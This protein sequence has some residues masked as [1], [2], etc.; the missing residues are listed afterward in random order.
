MVVPRLCIHAHHLKFGIL[1]FILE[2]VVTWNLKLPCT[3]IGVENLKLPNVHVRFE[4]KKTC[5]GT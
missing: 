2:F 1:I 5:I 3:Y 4:A